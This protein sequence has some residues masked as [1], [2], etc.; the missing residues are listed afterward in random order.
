MHVRSAD[1]PGVTPCCGRDSAADLCLETNPMW[2]LC[3]LTA[4]CLTLLVT[5]MQGP[6]GTPYE[7]GEFKLEVVISDRWV[8]AP[9]VGGTHLV[10]VPQQLSV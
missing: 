10:P 9:S 1:Y 8:G 5:A 6:S 2:L 7:G 3:L 4:L